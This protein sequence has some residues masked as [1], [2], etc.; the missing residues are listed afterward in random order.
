M[1][2]TISN[3]IS[4][5]DRY[6]YIITGAGCAGLS[7][8]MRLLQTPQLNQKK[9]L[10]LDRVAKNEN[11]RT[12][13]F[14]EKEVGLFESIVRHRWQRMHFY[15]DSFSKELN[16]T[17]YTYK[18]IRGIDLYDHVIH[19]TNQFPNVHFRYET[20]QSVS[21]EKNNAVVVTDQQTYYA[22]YIFNSIVLDQLSSISHHYFL[23]QHFKG[24]MIETSQP[25][26]DASS[27]TFMDFTVDQQQGTTFMYVLPVSSTKALVEYTLF[28]ETVLPEELYNDAL[29]QYI[30]AKLNITDYRIEHEEFAKIPMTNFPFKKQEGR[31]IHLGVAG[32]D[33]KASSGYTFQFI[34]KRTKKIVECLIQD[35]HPFIVETFNEKKFRFYDSVLLHVLQ[36]KKLNGDSIFTSIFSKNKTQRVLRFLDN[37]TNFADDFKIM[38]AVPMSVFLPAAL[39]ELFFNVL[40]IVR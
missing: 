15:A 28:T 40:N 3:I 18:M 20:V 35:H 24:W 10:V 38:R 23:W 21:T 39:R 13:C 6:D 31:V 11:D 19:F 22:D 29:K 27:A 16:L 17:P 37:E 32:G 9:I 5:S 34:Q 1:S 36:Y 26:F 30:N 25:V 14:W 33:T 12:W 4:T 8:L 7:L 2:D